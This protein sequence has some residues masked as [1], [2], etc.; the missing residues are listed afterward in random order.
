[1]ESTQLYTTE[2][3]TFRVAM[4]ANNRL[5]IVLGLTNLESPKPLEL[6]IM[7]DKDNNRVVYFIVDPTKPTKPKE[8]LGMDYYAVAHHVTHIDLPPLFGLLNALSKRFDLRKAD[9]TQRWLKRAADYCNVESME[10]LHLMELE[11]AHFHPFAREQYEEMQRL[12]AE[13]GTLNTVTK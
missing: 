4:E 13:Q 11:F 1:M 12:M 10:M 5:Y 3:F 9:H 8:T 2:N 6:Q 7:F